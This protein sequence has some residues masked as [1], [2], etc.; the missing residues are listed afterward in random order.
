MPL[1]EAGV[2]GRWIGAAETSMPPVA[3]TTTDATAPTGS[4]RGQADSRQLPVGI[5]VTRRAAPALDSFANPALG[6][7]PQ[8]SR[9]PAPAAF[10]DLL[11]RRP[12]GDPPGQAVVVSSADTAGLMVGSL[13]STSLSVPVPAAALPLPP[14]GTPP[15]PQALSDQVFVAVQRGDQQIELM[16]EPADLGRLRIQLQ[17]DG[18]QV[19]LQFQSANPAA[20]EAIESALP[21]LREML[22]DQGLQLGET[23]VGDQGHGARR[24][25]GEPAAPRHDGTPVSEPALT[26]SPGDVATG[27]DP[28]T[29]QGL[30]DLYA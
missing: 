12:V 20:R 4:G 6:T 10:A 14:G 3:S 5:E 30:I 2:T 7:P 13:S 27:A 25:P 16:L 9:N 26:P 24:Q 1:P 29:A 15:T 19:N 23:A 17:L 8:A 28:A 22:A 18:D 11:L 21:R